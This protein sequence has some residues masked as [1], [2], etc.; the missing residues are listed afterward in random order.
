MSY[1]LGEMFA[2]AASE[3][4]TAPKCAANTKY[5]RTRLVCTLG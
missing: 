2:H 3:V 1:G 5:S 4:H